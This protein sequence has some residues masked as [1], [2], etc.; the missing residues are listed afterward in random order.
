MLDIVFFVLMRTGSN[1]PDSNEYEKQ[2]TWSF[3]LSAKLQKTNH[4]LKVF[5]ILHF[6]ALSSFYNSHIFSLFM[7][8]VALLINKIISDIQIETTVCLKITAMTSQKKQLS[9]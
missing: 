5:L 2:F 9:F 7:E 8:Y 3:S 4:I 1:P 6:L